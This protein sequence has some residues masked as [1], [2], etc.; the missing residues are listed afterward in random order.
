MQQQSA[1]R[2]GMNEPYKCPARA[3][4]A[5]EIDHTQSTPRQLRQQSVDIRSFEGNMMQ[6]RT[7]AMEIASNGAAVAS[8]VAR[9]VRRRRGGFSLLRLVV[10]GLEKLQL[11]NQALRQERNEILENIRL[12]KTDPAELERIAR[13][14][15]QWA[16]PGDVILQPPRSDE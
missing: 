10:Q 7:A 3:R 5:F 1:Q 9:P 14:R 8:G 11:E 6:P 13:E 16:R 2:S 12:I 15:Y 4:P